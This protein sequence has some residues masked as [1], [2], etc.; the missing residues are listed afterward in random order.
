MTDI[1]DKVVVL[2][3]AA[4][5]IGRG[6]AKALTAEGAKLEIADKDEA[7]LTE[8][9]AM[10]GEGADAVPHILD[11]SSAEGWDAWAAD[12]LARRGHVDI[13]INN[14]GVTLAASAKDQ[15]HDDFAWLMGINFWG[16][17][18]GTQ[19]FM[20]QMLER[21]S[22]HIVN[23]SSIFGLFGVRNQSAYC[24]SKFAVRGYSDSVR[25]ELDRTG[26]NMTVVH[27][28]GIQT[29]LGRHMTPATIQALTDSISAAQPAGT[30]QCLQL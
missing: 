19:A 29:E 6:L 30:A 14:A 16:V 8:T 2:T 12:I 13:V 7:G 28:G 10:L 5:G 21:D 22:G 26:V 24:A 15:T 18:Y 17:V 27:P 9:L 20:P 4:S 1:K 23:V 25:V 3:G 11:V